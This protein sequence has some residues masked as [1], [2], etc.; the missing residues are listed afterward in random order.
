VVARFGADA[1]FARRRAPREGCRQSPRP[2]PIKPAPAPMRRPP[3]A[4]RRNTVSEGTNMASD[5]QRS[6]APTSR[7]SGFFALIVLSLVIGAAL[8]L[9]GGGPFAAWVDGLVAQARGA[10][11]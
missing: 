7:L 8:Y 1:G 5:T 4:R 11:G 6:Y 9:S 10:I 3:R 2:V